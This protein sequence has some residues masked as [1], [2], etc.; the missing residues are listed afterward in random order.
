MEFHEK[1]SFSSTAS[2]EHG[3][4]ITATNKALSIGFDI[5]R[6]RNEPNSNPVRAQVGSREKI[7]GRVTC[8]HNC[9]HNG[10]LGEICIAFHSVNNFSN[11]TS[12]SL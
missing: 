1:S 8:Q 12:T 9:V 4:T 6:P 2:S 11:V 3:M 5:L 10:I 7:P